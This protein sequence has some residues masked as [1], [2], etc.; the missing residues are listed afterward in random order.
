MQCR[1][2]HTFIHSLL[3]LALDFSHGFLETPASSAF[4]QAGFRIERI[5]DKMIINAMRKGNSKEKQSLRGS[6]KYCSR[7]ELSGSKATCRLITAPTCSSIKTGLVLTSYWHSEKA[8]AALVTSQTLRRMGKQHDKWKFLC[9]SSGTLL[10]W[11]EKLWMDLELSSQ[12]IQCCLEQ[13]H[14]IRLT[15]LTLIDTTCR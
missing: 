10:V 6:Y 12:Y 11:I 9:E 1:Y 5:L 15:S 3:L 13:T 8:M 4:I 2:T 14:W 7:T